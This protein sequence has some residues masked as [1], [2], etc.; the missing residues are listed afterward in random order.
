[1]RPAVFLARVKAFRYN[2]PLFCCQAL[3]P[4]MEINAHLNRIKD[5]SERSLSLRG[6]L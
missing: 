5:L 2:A 3:T 4:P 1:M 6:Y